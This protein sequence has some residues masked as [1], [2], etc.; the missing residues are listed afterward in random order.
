MAKEQKT[1]REL[2]EM[3]HERIGQLRITHLEV[4][5]DPA[6]GWAVFVVAP[7]QLV[8]RYQAIVDDIA[9]ELRAK[10]DLTE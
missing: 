9:R 1:A 6:I 10:Y 3:V 4:R 7:P 5:P 2:E 8:G